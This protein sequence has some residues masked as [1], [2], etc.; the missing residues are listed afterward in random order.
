[1]KWKKAVKIAAMT[2]I[3]GGLVAFGT[4][5]LVKKLRSQEAEKVRI[6]GP[7]QDEREKEEH[8]IHALSNQ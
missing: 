2:A 6:K 1:M 5:K 3:P 4:W 8:D 7:E